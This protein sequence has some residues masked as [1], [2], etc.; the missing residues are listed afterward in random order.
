MK[1]LNTCIAMIVALLF[2]LFGIE[3]AVATCVC[4]SNNGNIKDK[5]YLLELKNKSSNSSVL[6]CGT[7]KKQI[8]LHHIIASSIKVIDCEQKIIVLN[9]SKIGYDE[10]LCKI[11]KNENNVQITYWRNYLHFAISYKNN[12]IKIIKSNLPKIYINN[13]YSIGQKKLS[14]FKYLPTGKADLPW[15][16]SLA[17]IRII[18][19]KDK[20]RKRT[21][22]LV[23]HQTLYEDGSKIEIDF[24]PDG[25]VGSEIYQRGHNLNEKVT[26]EK[27]DY[28]DNNNLIGVRIQYFPDCSERE[29]Y[30]GKN[31]IF[32]IYV[33][34]NGKTQEIGFYPD[35]TKEYGP[36]LGEIKDVL[37][38]D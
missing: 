19:T 16:L 28:N 5:G 37:L 27:F 14:D 12:K 2:V 1:T 8:D 17:K 21:R 29:G 6:V 30:T 15:P 11:D 26:D 7:I 10:D 23:Y 36:D 3:L 31:P 18:S 24:T 4:P 32:I 25:A 13:R 33:F 38:F 35:G 34:K 9:I 20:H 22:K